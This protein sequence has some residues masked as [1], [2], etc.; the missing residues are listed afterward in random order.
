MQGLGGE[1]SDTDLVKNGGFIGNDFVEESERLDVEECL[2]G[3]CVEE[4]ALLGGSDRVVFNRSLVK[5]SRVA[6][7]LSVTMR[8][9][10]P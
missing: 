5:A 3:K 7:C 2:S 10:R 4:D 6:L 9:S 8:A 1:L